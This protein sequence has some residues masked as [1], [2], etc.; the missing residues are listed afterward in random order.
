[1]QGHGK[2]IEACL[3]DGALIMKDGKAEVVPALCA[4]CG[5]C[6]PACP[7]GAIQIAG[8]TLEQ[9]EAMVDMIVNDEIIQD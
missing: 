9:Y 5:A 4:G 7:E 1:M 6:V 2:C 8:S 3:R